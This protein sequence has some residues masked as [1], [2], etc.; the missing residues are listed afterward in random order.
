MV[1]AGGTT[2]GSLAV[3][4]EVPVELADP[5][6]RIADAPFLRGRTIAL[7]ELATQALAG[8]EVNSSPVRG[9]PD[10]GNLSQQG[11]DPAPGIP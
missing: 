5:S 4:A 11:V 8:L 2:G 1:Y 10:S 7:L 9:L 6:G 3:Q